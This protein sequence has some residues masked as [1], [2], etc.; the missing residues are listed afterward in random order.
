MNIGI[1]DKV[2]MSGYE[3]T[4]NNITNDGF[5][6]KVYSSAVTNEINTYVHVSSQSFNRYGII[7]EKAEE[8]NI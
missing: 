4:V 3:G 6:I 7:V 1:G 5:I 8:I 2:K